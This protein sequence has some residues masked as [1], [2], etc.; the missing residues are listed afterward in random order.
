MNL[1]QVRVS[2]DG[3]Q[4]ALPNEMQLPLP[5]CGCPDH[6]NKLVILGIRPEHFSL[7]EKEDA[8]IRMTVDHVETLGADTL[9][10]GRLNAEE[11]LVTIRLPD[12][13]RF[14]KHRPLD[15]SVPPEKIHLFDVD[16][17]KRIPI[18]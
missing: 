14:E 2:S 16:T 17:Q 10:H 12:I 15:L 5:G 1:L 4:L 13:R 9:V 7:G 18:S 11:S 8:V 3:R 6:G